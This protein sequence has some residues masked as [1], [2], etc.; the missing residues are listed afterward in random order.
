MCTQELRKVV[1][2]HKHQLFKSFDWPGIKPPGPF[3]ILWGGRGEWDTRFL[4]SHGWVKERVNVG[5]P[6]HRSCGGIYTKVSHRRLFLENHDGIA[7]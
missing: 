4:G 1:D 2:P 5:K 3:L 7:D 6:G